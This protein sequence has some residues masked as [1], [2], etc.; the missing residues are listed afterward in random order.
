V[1]AVA[2]QSPDRDEELAG[3]SRWTRDGLRGSDRADG[4]RTIGGSHGGA[5]RD[6]IETGRCEGA[7]DRERERERERK[8]ERRRKRYMPELT[9]HAVKF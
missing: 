6:H 2:Y 3:F 5:E 7:R 8:R 9:Q 4:N 1:A